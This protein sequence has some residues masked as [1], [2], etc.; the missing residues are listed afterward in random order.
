M[1]CKLIAAMW[2]GL[3]PAWGASPEETDAHNDEAR[4]CHL[5]CEAVDLPGTKN[6]LEIGGFTVDSFHTGAGAMG[7]ICTN[8]SPPPR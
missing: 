2:R 3:Y 4:S 7:R 5:L 6:A 1:K 8:T